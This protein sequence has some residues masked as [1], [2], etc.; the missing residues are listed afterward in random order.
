[1]KTIKH[2]IAPQFDNGQKATDT[3]YSDRL[4]QWD[5][6]KHDEICRRIWGNEGQFWGQR[7]PEEIEQFLCEYFGMNVRLCRIE[8]DENKSTGYPLW[9]FDFKYIRA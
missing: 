3:V 5:H 8:Q 2:Y 4:F 6:A 1:M 7:K 9:R